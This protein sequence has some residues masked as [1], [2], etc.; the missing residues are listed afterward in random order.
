MNRLVKL[1]HG[2]FTKI[3]ENLFCSHEHT[4]QCDV[5]FISNN[6]MCQYNSNVLKHFYYV[7]TGHWCYNNH[8]EEQR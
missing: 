4:V 8:K 7:Y 3:G 2:A 6:D 1:L 5:Q